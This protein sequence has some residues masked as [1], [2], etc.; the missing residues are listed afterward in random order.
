MLVEQRTYTL[1]PGTAGQYL[2]LYET[3]GMAIQK[4]I[5]GRLVGYYQTEF[6]TLNQVIHMWAYES[7][8]ERAA[9]RA[10]LGA[11][12]AWQAYIGKTR[13]L[14]ITQ[15]NKLLIPAPF[16]TVKWQD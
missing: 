2:K 1:H 12:P 10:R 11:D 13:P 7:L 16:L 5:L 3:E 9:K 14:I 4:P 8:D 6:G 15:E